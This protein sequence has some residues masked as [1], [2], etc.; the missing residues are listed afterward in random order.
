L[1]I[2]A[3]GLVVDHALA[4]VVHDVVRR[5]VAGVA[6]GDD[7]AG[8]QLDPLVD[9]VEADHLDPGRHP[10]ARPQHHRIEV[11][12]GPA[13]QQREA[14]RV[15]V[16]GRHAPPQRRHL[17]VVRQAR[18]LDHARR[19]RR[20]RLEDGGLV[21]HRLGPGGQGDR[22]LVVGRQVLAQRARVL[23]GVVGRLAR[24]RLRLGGLRV[25]QLGVG[26]RVLGGRLVGLRH[27][28][29]PA[30]MRGGEDR[31]ERPTVPRPYP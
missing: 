14:R 4:L 12:L 8:A 19:G 29:P 9:V 24:R 28:G 2:W 11:L 20:D 18:G 27:G 1:P 15:H 6:L 17:G 7:R 5:H 22:R 26:R 23:G 13:D 16:V 3:L 10:V 31:C 21:E 30:K 25:L